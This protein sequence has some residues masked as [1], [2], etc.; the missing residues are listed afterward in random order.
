MLRIEQASAARSGDRWHVVWRI[1]N[2][3]P[4]QV[5]IVSA[6]LPHS[7]FRSDEWQIAPPMVI[8]PG[9]EQPLDSDVSC[10]ATPGAV[11]ENAFLI[12]RLRDQRVFARLR[13]TIQPDGAPQAVT[14]TVT[15][16][17]AG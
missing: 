1:G 15:S 5:E 12:L 8:P 16:Q 2:P 3:D 11:V 4:E 17:P 6:W 13:V 7:G 14:E 10:P 9:G